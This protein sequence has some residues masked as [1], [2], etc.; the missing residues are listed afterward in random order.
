MDKSE[1]RTTLPSDE[2]RPSPGTPASR[3]KRMHAGVNA[4]LG[5]TE[6]QVNMTKTVPQRIDPAGSKI[7]DLAGT[8]GHDS[9]GG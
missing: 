4:A 5:A 7:E 1:D 3:E 8:G 6:E 9:Q 2:H